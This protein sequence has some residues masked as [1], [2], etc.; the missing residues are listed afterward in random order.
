MTDTQVEVT[1]PKTA[2]SPRPRGPRTRSMIV[3]ASLGGAFLVWAFIVPLVC[4]GWR[5][6]LPALPS[7]RLE[8]STS[9][10]P[11]EPPATRVRVLS[12]DLL[13]VVLRPLEAATGPIEVRAFLE[14][15]GKNLRWPVHFE[16]LAAG[17]FAV[18][19]AARELS[20]L[21]A[22][23][24]QAVVLVG[25]PDRLPIHPA[26]A[27]ERAPDDTW[28]ILY[29]ELDVVGWPEHRAGANHGLDAAVEKKYDR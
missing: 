27:R 5:E 22:G 8:L 6:S 17:T 3:A 20:G 29:G 11:Q 21:G 2:E 28:C 14:Q 9:T 19:V 4:R 10:A 24:W 16:R 18:T 25:R 12:N 1:S 13:T 15:P 26:A 23:R 7:Y